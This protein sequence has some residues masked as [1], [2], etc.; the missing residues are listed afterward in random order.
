MGCHSLEA[1]EPHKVGPNLA[2]IA[3]QPAGTRPGF[4]YSEAL[5]EAGT[6]NALVWE[7]GSLMAWIL[8]TET[9][10]PGTWMLYYNSLSVEEMDGCV[11]YSS[12]DRF[13]RISR[14]M[15]DFDSGNSDSGVKYAFDI[16][17]S[18]KAPKRG[19][20]CTAWSVVY[21]VRNM[22]LFFKT[23]ENPEVR[24][25]E[26]DDFDLSCAAPVMVLDMNANLSG[27]SDE[28][29]E[30]DPAINKQLVTEVMTAYKESG[31]LSEVSDAAIQMLVHYPD[32]LKCQYEGN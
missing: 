4:V 9:M 8:Q 14:A 6:S 19:S 1:G 23:S 30:Y 18:V 22:Q 28:F 31:F 13:V 11:S 2:D 32:M 3:G 20:H 16:L 12:Q 27:S 17:E 10:V 21:D 24:I 29:V 5:R 15:Q 25:V 7:K 26:F